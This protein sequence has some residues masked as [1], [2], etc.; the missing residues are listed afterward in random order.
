MAG[1]GLFDCSKTRGSGEPAAIRENGRRSQRRFL[2]TITS[3]K[4]PRAAAAAPRQAHTICPVIKLPGKMFT[5]CRIQIRPMAIRQALRIF[6]AMRMVVPPPAL[7]RAPTAVGKLRDQ[8]RSALAADC[9]AKSVAGAR[10]DVPDPTAGLLGE[11]AQQHFHR[12]AVRWV[13]IQRV[14]RQIVRPGRHIA[15]NCPVV[16][17]VVVQNDGRSAGRH[18]THRI[19][20]GRAIEDVIQH[21]DVRCLVQKHLAAPAQRRVIDILVR[22]VIH[23]VDMV[24]LKHFNCRTPIVIDHVIGNQCPSCVRRQRVIRRAIRGVARRVDNDSFA[25]GDLRRI[26]CRH[27]HQLRVSVN[28]VARMNIL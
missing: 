8:S 25:I 9:P 17:K 24:A 11:T 3:S 27:R 2:R 16:V 15:G 23:H 5:P 1:F 10:F 20:P 19:L 14:G 18:R 26:F 6:K 22:R 12:I 28:S 7:V 13:R 21:V 4:R